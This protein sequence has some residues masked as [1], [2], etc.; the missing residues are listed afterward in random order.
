MAARLGGGGNGRHSS[1]GPGCPYASR[2][3][4]TPEVAHDMGIMLPKG[5]LLTEMPPA[6]GMA[7]VV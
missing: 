1:H 2:P 5:L 4:H 7:M 6:V 3:K